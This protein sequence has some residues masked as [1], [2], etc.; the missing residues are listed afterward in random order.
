MPE[1]HTGKENLVFN[2]KEEGGNIMFVVTV[3]V[4]L[5][6]FVSSYKCMAQVPNIDSGMWCEQGNRNIHF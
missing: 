3:T 1:F 5:Y 6:A 4:W 2:R